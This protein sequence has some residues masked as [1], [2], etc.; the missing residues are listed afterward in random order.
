MWIQPKIVYYAGC[1]PGESRLWRFDR[2]ITHIWKFYVKSM[3]LFRKSQ[4]IKT[5][6][7]TSPRTTEKPERCTSEP[8]TFQKILP[9]PLASERVAVE[10]F[11]IK[12]MNLMYMDL[13][14]M[15]EPDY[16]G[17]EYYLVAGLR[18]RLENDTGVLLPW[19]VPIESTAQAP[20]ADAVFQVVNQSHNASSCA[21]MKDP[22]FAEFS[23]ME[24]TSLTIPHSA[25]AL[26][27]SELVSTTSPPYQPKSNGIAE[28]L[29]IGYVC[30]NY[31]AAHAAD[32]LRH[33]ALK[34]TYPTPAFGE[35]VGVYAPQD[36]GK[37][38]ALEPRGTVGRFLMC[39]TWWTGAT[40]IVM[41][42]DGDYTIMKGLKPLRA[43]PDMVQLATPVVVPEGWSDLAVQALATL[44]TVIRIPNGNP[45][46][47]RLA[48]GS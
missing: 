34:I 21:N 33:R 28:R 19:F 36:K 6:R 37:V 29:W 15:N 39:D 23:R 47:V 35:N 44:W 45:L 13:G 32:V 14:K 8:A 38:K 30:W 12:D 40:H 31:A 22:L 20:V 18:V 1:R 16:F 9:A 48:D 4:N 26:L 46:W 24:N 17:H 27:I 11:T 43:D 5:W 3:I 42:Q 25:S 10:F 7:R 2:S 41:P